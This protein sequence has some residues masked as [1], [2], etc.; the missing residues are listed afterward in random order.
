MSIHDIP[1]TAGIVWLGD[2]NETDPNTVKTN[3]SA[4]RLSGHT[5][6]IVATATAPQDLLAAIL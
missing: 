3:T 2:Y 6:W 1:S 4:S 5:A